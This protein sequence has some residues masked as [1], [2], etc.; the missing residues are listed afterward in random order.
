ML[1]DLE[2]PD[3]KILTPIYNDNKGCVD[4][5][6]SDAVTKQLLYLNIRE[7][8]VRDS[9]LAS[10]ITIE[11]ID[12]KVNPSD[13]LT[14]EMKDTPHFLW[15]RDLMVCDTSS[16]GGVGNPNPTA[17]H[18]VLP[19]QRCALPSQHG[20]YSPAQHASWRAGIPVY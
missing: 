7:F 3:A 19:S 12:G 4:W 11:H 9:R 18:S 16:M 5:A 15:L 17:R 8:A 2:Q 14:K 20:P 13:I 1:T 6:K 10:N